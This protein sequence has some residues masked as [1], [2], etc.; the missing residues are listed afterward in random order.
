MIDGVTRVVGEETGMFCESVVGC[1]ICGTGGGGML[2]EFGVVTG[3]GILRGE[4]VC[5]S[6]RTVLMV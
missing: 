6:D 1:T 5:T 4:L 3:P 2:E